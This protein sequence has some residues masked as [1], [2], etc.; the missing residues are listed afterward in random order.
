MAIVPWNDHIEVVTEGGVTYAKAHE[1]FTV[2]ATAEIA[3]IDTTCLMQG[4]LVLDISTGKISIWDGSQW[5]EVTSGGGGSG[6]STLMITWDLNTNLL[7]KT[8]KEI[9]DHVADG[10]MAYITDGAPEDNPPFVEYL[11]V[12]GVNVQEGAYQVWESRGGKMWVAA[13]I[14]DYPEYTEW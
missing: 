8:F 7:D 1:E 13:T 10:G 3:D 5:V 2:S 12:G 4:S 9:S 14:N 6:M 11:L